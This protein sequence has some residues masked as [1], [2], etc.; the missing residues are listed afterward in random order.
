MNSY[1]KKFFSPEPCGETT[2][3]PVLRILVGI[4]MIY[5]GWESFD[6]IKIHEYATWEPTKSLPAPLL[7]VYIGKLS[8]LA[9]GLLLLL[10]LFTRIGVL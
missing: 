5:H 4:F 3:L 8:E 7:L 9:G 1:I 10:G 2:G 6:T